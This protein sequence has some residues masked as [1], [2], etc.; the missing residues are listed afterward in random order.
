MAKDQLLW[1]QTGIIYQVYPRSFKDTN[2]DGI[3]DLQGICEK[4]DY[5]S[6]LGIEALWLSPIFP[7]PMVDFGYDI[8]DF[9]GIDPL[10]GDL[11][12]FDH[13]IREA[14]ARNLRVILDFVPNHS[15]DQHEWF[16]Q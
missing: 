2:D 11:A 10:F 12:I 9:T 4:L 14:H 16:R 5:L 7:S 6:W 15:S 13:F 8:A 1:W 3:G